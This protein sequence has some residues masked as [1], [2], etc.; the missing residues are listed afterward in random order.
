MK[1]AIIRQRYS[2]YGGAERFVERALAALVAE[3]VEV[4]LIT[5]SWEGAP[6]TGFHQINCD[7]PYTRLSGGRVAR[8]R[9]FATAA[10]LLMAQGSYDI[11][12]A[13]ERIP[14]CRIFRAGDGV[15][16]AWLE[17]RT[18][19]L[20]APAR[21]AQ[22]LS[23]YHRYVLAAER[24]MLEHPALARVICNSRLIAQE[25][26]DYYALPAS[27]IALIYNGVDT[28]HFHPERAASLRQD[29]RARLG[30]AP[31]TPLLLFVGSGFARK[32]VPTLLHALARMRRQEAQLLVVG[33]DRKLAAMQR[34]ANRLGL[35]AR[36]RF[37][38]PL[39]EVLP[40]YGAADAFVL[41]TLY[42]PGPNAALEAM[43]CGL[44]V[45]TSLSC[46]ARD[47]IEPGKNGWVTDAL[48]T[49]ALARALDD[50]CELATQPAA[51][52][53]AR[54]AVAHLSLEAM[55][56]KLLQLYRELSANTSNPPKT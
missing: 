45:V 52:Q 2:P 30:L 42:D 20:S 47:W 16:R 19:Q 4:D 31:S 46:G 36:V 1:L 43:S 51:H 27:K 33:A 32:G 9:S 39:K 11:T 48:D 41:P 44:P 53:S 28:A 6:A 29:A 18:R 14:G 23:P 35:G 38:G 55:S 24:A 13:H 5:R 56:G 7:P 34:L 12:Q 17:H 37:T 22:R 10:Q 21:L 26:Q 25:L 3:G 15:H 49:A 40:C 54:S 8:D 50:L